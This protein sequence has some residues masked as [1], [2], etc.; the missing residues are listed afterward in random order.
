M[1]KSVRFPLLPSRPEDGEDDNA[2]AEHFGRQVAIWVPKPVS[3]VWLSVALAQASVDQCTKAVSLSSMRRL[4]PAT[5]TVRLSVSRQA[6]RD[7]RL[8]G[9][10][11]GNSLG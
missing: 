11:A 4:L 7:R 10:V 8:T 3:R 9:D 5:I 6:R 2:W 1:R